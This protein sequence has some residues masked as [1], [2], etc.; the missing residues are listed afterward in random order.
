MLVVV[1]P[2]HLVFVRSILDPPPLRGASREAV[3][4]VHALPPDSRVIT[5][6]IGLVWRAGRTT[7]PDL[8]DASIKQFEQHRITEPRVARAARRGDVC[9]VLVWRDTYL[10]S[11]RQLPHDLATAGYAVTER[12]QGA[13]GARVLYERVTACPGR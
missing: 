2:F 13:H 6:E 5:D 12:F 8:V 11:F 4:A 1:L 9:A 7:P 10:G 3:R